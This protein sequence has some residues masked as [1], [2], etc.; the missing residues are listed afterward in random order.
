MALSRNSKRRNPAK[1]SGVAPNNELPGAGTIAPL[2]VSIR[3]VDLTEATVRM[4][5][6]IRL[7]LGS[8]GEDK[9]DT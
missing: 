8:P 6:A 1:S 9:K 2:F 5:R 3:H 4:Q 7:I